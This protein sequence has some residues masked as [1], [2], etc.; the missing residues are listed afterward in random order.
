MKKIIFLFYIFLF[1]NRHDNI[2]EDELNS[3]ITYI[4]NHI[5]K[6][7]LVEELKLLVQIFNFNSLFINN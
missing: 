4:L 2:K 5:K 6:K 1:F 7:Y 3:L